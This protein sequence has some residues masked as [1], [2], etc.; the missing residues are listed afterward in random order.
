MLTTIGTW[1]WANP[2]RPYQM[3]SKYSN[4]EDGFAA[5]IV[6]FG[7]SSICYHLDEP[8]TYDRLNKVLGGWNIRPSNTYFTN[9]D[10]DYWRKV[11]ID[12]DLPGA[13]KVEVTQE[14]PKCGVSPGTDKVFGYTI[15]NATHTYDIN[16]GNPGEVTE[17]PKV[18]A[19]FHT[20]LREWLLCFHA[21]K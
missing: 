19:L 12:S 14:I 2:D 7:N 5:C 10:M 20:A 16:G 3:V 15:S 13:P 1:W 4:A 18:I 21:K 6:Q 11:S 17:R 9:G 8:A